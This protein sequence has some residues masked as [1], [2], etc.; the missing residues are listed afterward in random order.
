MDLQ[1]NCMKRQKNINI[2]QYW[3]KYLCY[4]FCAL[5]YQLG[6]NGI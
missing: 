2:G 4:Y 5:N 1:K 3:M 6:Q